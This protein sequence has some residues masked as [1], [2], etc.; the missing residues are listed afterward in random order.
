MPI[1]KI[2]ERGGAGE[3]RQTSQTTRRGISST[4]Q[5]RK[6]YFFPPYTHTHTHPL[7][8]APF[9][10][11]AQKIHQR[12]RVLRVNLLISI[13]SLGG[14]LSTMPAAYFGMNLDSGLEDLPGMFWPMVQ[15]SVASGILVSSM[16]YTYYRYGP[17]RRYAARLRDMRS[18]RDL[19]SYHMDDLDAII[20]AVRARG[21]LSKPDFASVVQAA[22]KGKPMSKEEVALLF[23][24]FDQNKNAVLELSELMKLEELQEGLAADNEDPIA[25]HTS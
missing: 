18:L 16:I 21:R 20:E 7:N 6:R 19:L 10:V 5:Q 4:K 1:G 11:F 12:N 25:H 17:K 23:R 13:A 22:V 15:G 9:N 2:Q 14:L 3:G 8:H 24:V